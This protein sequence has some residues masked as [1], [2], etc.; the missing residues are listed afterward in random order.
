RAR[1][2]IARRDGT[3]HARIAALELHF[4]NAKRYEFVWLRSEQLIFPE[5]R[6]AV[7]FERSAE[8]QPHVAGGQSGKHG[9]GRVERGS[10]NYGRAVG[11]RIIGKALG[12]VEHGDGQVDTGAKALRRVGGT[13][14]EFDRCYGGE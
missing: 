4:A 11:D 12:R 1:L 9:C 5:G 3:A 7:D 2:R 10:G 8:T 6:D 13:A 14:C